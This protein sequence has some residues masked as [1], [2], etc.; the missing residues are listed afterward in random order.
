MKTSHVPFG[1]LQR[2]LQQL[3]F[4]ERRDQNGWRFEHAPSNTFFL[5]RAYRP[6]DRVYEHD[7]FLVRSQLNGR[8]L[9]SEDAFDESLT[10][11]P[12]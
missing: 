2:F 1:Q 5:F 11:T 3:G 10:K 9:M 4:S 6:T 7:L 12:A 8:G